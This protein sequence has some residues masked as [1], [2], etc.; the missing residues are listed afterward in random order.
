MFFEAI[1]KFIY[2]SD[3]RFYSCQVESSRFDRSH[4]AESGVTEHNKDIHLLQTT[5]A[6][7]TY[8]HMF[9]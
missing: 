2:L 6:W 9:C 4:E 1:L 5:T 7:T 8:S 3:Y